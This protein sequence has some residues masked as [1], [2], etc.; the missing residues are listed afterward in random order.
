MNLRKDHSHASKH[1]T[2]VNSG[3]E[4]LRGEVSVLVAEI[5]LCS[6]LEGGS[7]QDG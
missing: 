1:L 2:T 6:R 4:A 5:S 3:C 7:V